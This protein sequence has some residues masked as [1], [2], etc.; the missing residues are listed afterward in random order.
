MVNQAIIEA[1]RQ[2][3]AENARRFAVLREL[4][5]DVASQLEDLSSPQS[6]KLLANAE[7]AIDLW[8]REHTCSPV[9]VKMWRRV[10]KQPSRI[11]SHVLGN[12]DS[13]NAL[14]QNTPFGFML[15]SKH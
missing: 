6:R 12:S 7:R 14:M 10:L 8:E 4:H 13:G 5:E 3:L 9:Y 15:R 2:A 1:R 11:R